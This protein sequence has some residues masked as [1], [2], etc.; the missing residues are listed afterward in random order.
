MKYDPTEYPLILSEEQK[1]VLADQLRCCE[2]VREVQEAQIQKTVDHNMKVADPRERRKPAR[3][4][5]SPL[6]SLAAWTGGNSLGLWAATNMGMMGYP[7]D[8]IV[9]PKWNHRFTYRGPHKG[10]QQNDAGALYLPQ[11]NHLGLLKVEGIMSPVAPGFRLMAVTFRVIPTSDLWSVSLNV[12]SKPLK[13]P[14][15]SLL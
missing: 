3:V 8:D 15:R 4:F 11:L 10:I 12:S 7:I 5:G 13:A 6:S 9:S 14:R 2:A 1:H